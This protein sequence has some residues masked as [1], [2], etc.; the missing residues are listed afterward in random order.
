ME[1]KGSFKNEYWRENFTSDLILSDPEISEIE[2]TN[3]DEFVLFACDGLWDVFDNQDAVDFVKVSM[4]TYRDPKKAIFD[5]VDEAIKMGSMDN[6]SV[7]AVFW[8]AGLAASYGPSP[9]T[10]PMIR[11]SAISPTKQF[12]MMMEM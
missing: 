2:I 6:V 9:S 3:E 7:L 10:S 4:D 1:F 12:N 5:L 8:P 11:G